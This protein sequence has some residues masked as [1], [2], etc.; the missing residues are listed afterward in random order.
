MEIL[1]NFIADNALYWT[2]CF[3]VGCVMGKLAYW[4]MH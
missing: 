2:I 1:M 3:I 4:I